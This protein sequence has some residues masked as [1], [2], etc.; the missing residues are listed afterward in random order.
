M[1]KLIHRIPGSPLLISSLLG[2]ALRTCVKTLG[3]PCDSTAFSKPCLVNLIS[4]D[5]HLVFYILL[6]PFSFVIFQI[7][8]D[9]LSE[10]TEEFIYDEIHPKKNIATLKFVKPKGPANRGPRRMMKPSNNNE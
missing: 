6:T 3:K 5:T 8:V 2:S 4:K 1:S 10:I 9:D 7:E